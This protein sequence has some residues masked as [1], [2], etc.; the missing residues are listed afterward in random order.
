MLLAQAN[1]GI[2]T[3]EKMITNLWGYDFKGNEKIIDT[4]IKNLHSKL[5][6][7]VIQTVKGMGYRLY[8]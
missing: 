5:P 3:R 1:G 7:P 2:V 4:H 6:F 8:T